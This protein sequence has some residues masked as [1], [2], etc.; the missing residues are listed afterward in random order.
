MAKGYC[1]RTDVANLLGITFT[2]T[3]NTEADTLINM[4]EQYIDRETR[5]GWIIP[6]IVNERYNLR[7]STLYLR[8]RPIASVQQI[9]TR[10]TAINDLLSTAIANVDYEIFDLNLAQI[11]FQPGYAG[12][13]A[14]AFVDYTPNL[15]AVPADINYAAT[16]IVANTMFPVL[17]PGIYGIAKGVVDRDVQMTYTDQ[18]SQLRIPEQA[19]EIIV[20]YRL[21]VFA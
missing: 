20:G 1:T 9:R 4:A 11:N 19:R 13:R 3:Q 18:A 8:Y 5:R 15:N 12:P 7:T 14:V 16:L 10:T 21:P 6:P 17:N 2:S